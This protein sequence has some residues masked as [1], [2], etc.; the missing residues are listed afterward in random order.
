[1]KLKITLSKGEKTGL[2]CLLLF[3][4][5]T[6]L[7]IWTG[8]LVQESAYPY[9]ALFFWLNSL[10]ALPTIIDWEWWWDD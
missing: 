8:I 5:W 1:M 4:V 9:M 7:T 2:L 3:L 10:V 6:P